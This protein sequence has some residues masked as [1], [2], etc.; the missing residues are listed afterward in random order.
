MPIAPDGFGLVCRFLLR[1]AH[2]SISMIACSSAAAA[3]LIDYCRLADQMGKVL[4]FFLFF[5][6]FFFRDDILKRCHKWGAIF[7]NRKI[8]IIFT[9][10]DFCHLLVEF[11]R[12]KVSLA[13]AFTD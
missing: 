1:P 13:N 3:A 12:V 8:A 7:D 10:G 9:H 4:F 6:C 5:E 2:C 11:C